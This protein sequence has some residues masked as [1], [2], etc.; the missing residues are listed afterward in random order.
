MEKLI[1][2]I[3]KEHEQNLELSLKLD[4][5]LYYGWTLKIIR[6]G[7]DIPILEITGKDFNYVLEK[8]YSMLS[9]INFNIY[10]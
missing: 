4:Y 7:Y 10:K 1:D 6:K 9:D 8:T 3:K 2:Y 5:S